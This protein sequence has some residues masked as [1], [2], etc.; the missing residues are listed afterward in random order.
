MNADQKNRFRE[1]RSALEASK[2]WRKT[3][4]PA[5]RDYQLVYPGR[6]DRP[7]IGVTDPPFVNLLLSTVQV[8][9]AAST[10]EDPSFEALPRT[11]QFAQYQPIVEGAL[12]ITWESTGAQRE[13]SEALTDRFVT[14]DGWIKT[15]W[16][17]IE[18][19]G[20]LDPDL[21][22]Q[23]EKN[24]QLV[25]VTRGLGPD[26]I[27]SRAQVEAHVLKNSMSL[28]SNRPIVRRIDPFAMYVDSRATS[29]KDCQW[30]AQ[31]VWLPLEEV[32]ENEAFNKKAREAIKPTNRLM[33]DSTGHNPQSDTAATS[34]EGLQECCVWELYDVKRRELTIFADGIGD[35]E[36]VLFGPESTQDELGYPH[37]FTRIPCI[38]VPGAYYSMG[39]VEA[40]SALQS[41]LNDQRLNM[42]ELRRAS[43]PKAFTLS[44][45]ADQIREWVA[46]GDPGFVG[47]IDD[48]D[49]DLT[50]IIHFTTPPM[51]SPILFQHGAELLNDLDRQVGI[52]AMERG[53]GLPGS[54]TAT[55]VNAITGYISARARNYL[56]GS[57]AA[58][59]EV[60]R[61]II[62]LMQNNMDQTD[63]LWLQEEFGMDWLPPTD[64]GQPV[65]N[66]RS[67][68]MGVP[69]S[70]SMLA[71]EW[72]LKIRVD[73]GT[74]DG[75]ARR[76]QKAQQ[77]LQG[78][79]PFMSSGTAN[80]IEIFRKYLSDIG[81]VNP[82][83]FLAPQAPVQ[84]PPTG[85][86]GGMPSPAGQNATAV[87][88]GA[89]GAGL[90]PGLE[91]LLAEAGQR[92]ASAAQ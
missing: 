18:G 28:I 61:R 25:A 90:P 16:E 78:A 65:M 10:V 36:E 51:V 88:S 7:N 37:P 82:D 49:A 57:R 53:V 2:N 55:E 38:F 92:G 1:L 33:D 12:D 81:I 47:E 5:W 24:L 60:A 70:G 63:Y 68:K 17:R 73:T 86:P 76:E 23:M 44:K 22:E 50:K 4:D 46:S 9:V 19:P 64:M 83:R 26:E 27:P 11:P 21:V 20:E 79:M 75:S 58:M 74:A 13:F 6:H 62:T 31:K 89:T 77:F 56:R 66:P 35:N 84:A 91:S 67:K 48:D 32:Q 87:G 43:I 41:E 72:Q 34:S 15:T 8:A 14:G 30:Y 54:S 3:F 39:F 59:E 45:Y 40:S 42:A 29:D 80:N 52:S 85:V 69:F 71:G